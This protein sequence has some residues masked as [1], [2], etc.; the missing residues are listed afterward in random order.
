VF[1]EIFHPLGRR[2]VARCDAVLRLPGASAGS[3]EM[4]ALAEA[5]GVAVY[6]RVEDVPPAGLSHSPR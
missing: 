3:D 6:H 4:V 2:L 5:A 1:D